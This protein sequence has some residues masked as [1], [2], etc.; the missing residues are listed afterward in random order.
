MEHET[1]AWS[2]SGS[3]DANPVSITPFNA[4]NEKHDEKTVYGGGGGD[5]ENGH[6]T[7]VEV[8]LG[9]VLV[10]GDEIE[11][12]WDADTSPFAAVRA[13]VPETDDPDMPVNTFRAWFLG[14]VFVFV[15]AGVD[16]FFSFRYPGVHIVALVAELLAYP[17]GVGLANVLPISRWNPDRHFNVKEHALVTIMS[18]VS[19]GFG[20]ADATNI[21]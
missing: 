20:S 4:H 2:R 14:I 8:D 19:F 7:E 6:L 11:G 13:V 17:L 10:E 21:I 1:K 9:R 16:Q 3:D 5:I 18:N 15:G 12:D